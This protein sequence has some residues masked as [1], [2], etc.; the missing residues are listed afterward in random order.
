MSRLLLFILLLL[1]V[2]LW[3]VSLNETDSYPRY[4]YPVGTAVAS[5]SDYALWQQGTESGI[6]HGRLSL[7]EGTLAF[8]S[9]PYF[10]AVDVLPVQERLSSQQTAG[11]KKLYYSISTDK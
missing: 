2:R 1:P 7:Q 9:Q 6:Y 3:A 4:I 10:K 5:G 8:H 11:N